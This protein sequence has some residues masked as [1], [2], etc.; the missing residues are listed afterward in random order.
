MDFW[1][2]IFRT[3]SRIYLGMVEVLQYFDIDIL[4][5]SIEDSVELLDM[6]TTFCRCILNIS[7]YE[8][9]WKFYRNRT[10]LHKDSMAFWWKNKFKMKIR[11][12]V[13]HCCW[14]DFC[15]IYKILTREFFYPYKI[16]TQIRR[17]WTPLTKLK[18]FKAYMWLILFYE[19]SSD[20]TRC[21]LVLF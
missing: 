5:E 6:M 17:S 20:T 11:N 9:C 4:W 3:S 15:Y 12:I 7:D 21:F 1:T 16:Q 8:I 2:R 10:N 19:M 18:Q 13:V 14:F